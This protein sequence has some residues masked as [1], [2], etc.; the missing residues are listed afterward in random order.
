MRQDELNVTSWRFSFFLEQFLRFC[1]TG[2]QCFC[3]FFL[4]QQFFW[5]GIHRKQQIFGLHFLKQQI[6]IV[7]LRISRFVEET[8]HVALKYHLVGTRNG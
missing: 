3:F 2:Q 1:F 7:G 8:V 5:V 4:T 6:A